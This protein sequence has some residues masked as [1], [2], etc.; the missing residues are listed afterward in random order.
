M[1][2]K[3]SDSVSVSFSLPKDSFSPIIVNRYLPNDTTEQ[4]GRIEQDFSEGDYPVYISTDNSGEK[5]F[6]PTTD[7]TTAE[8][9]FEKYAYELAEKA[10]ATAREEAYKEMA[11]RTETLNKLR[12][13]KYRQAQ[14]LSLNY[15]TL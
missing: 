6:P 15:L 8:T 2:T 5:L 3:S 14:E 13:K 10:L 1:K 7:W 12:N 4:I 11:E 9:N